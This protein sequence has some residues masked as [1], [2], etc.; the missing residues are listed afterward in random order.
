MK[1]SNIWT[2]AVR[3]ARPQLFFFYRDNAD[4]Y[5]SSRTGGAAVACVRLDIQFYVS[6]QLTR[7]S[8]TQLG[9]GHPKIIKAIT[10]QL[11]KLTYT[12]SGAFTHPS[13]EALANKLIA[14]SEGAFSKVLFLSGG[15][16]SVEAMIKLS[17]QYW[18]ECGKP[19]RKN[20]I[21]RKMS[22]HGNTLGA[23]SLCDH[24]ARC[25]IYM[26]LL[27]KSNFHHVSPAYYYRYAEAGESEEAYVQRLKDELDAKFQVCLL[28][29]HHL[30]IDSHR[31][32]F[33]TGAGP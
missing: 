13:S 20:F 19:E 3:V 14:S 30:Q 26:P 22:Y 2:P 18:I 6:P 25:S 11:Q 15:S 21:A 32:L 16:E 33:S 29:T 10:D 7:S 5:S 12:Y 27:N 17:R 31:Q 23:L 1:V 4:F 28:A 9:S 24:P 8:W